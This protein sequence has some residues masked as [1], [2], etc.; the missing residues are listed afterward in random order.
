VLESRL[1]RAGHQHVDRA[2]DGADKDKL[3]NA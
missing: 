1:P 3:S 2:Q